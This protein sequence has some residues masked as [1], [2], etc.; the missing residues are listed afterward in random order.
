[1]FSGSNWCKRHRQ[2]VYKQ[3]LSQL[4]LDLAIVRF[5][6]YNHGREVNF[7]SNCA[8]TRS[9]VAFFG[10]LILTF[11]WL[12][13]DFTDKATDK[14]VSERDTAS[15]A[16]PCRSHTR[17][18]SSVLFRYRCL[19]LASSHF[20]CTASGSKHEAENCGACTERLVQLASH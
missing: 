7:L 10:L 11:L 1:M 14:Q 15:A 6:L 8:S 2:Y 19:L 4:Y 12:T 20:C 5:L 18:H 16:S 9:D 3:F 17:T 13:H